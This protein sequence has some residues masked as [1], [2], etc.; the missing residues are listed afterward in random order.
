LQQDIT[1]IRPELSGG[2]APTQT[3][4]EAK[5]RKDQAL[6]QLGPQAAEMLAGAK[7][8]GRNLVVQ[9]AR[10]GSG[11]IKSSRKTSFGLQTDA[12]ELAMLAE[13]GWHCDTDGQWPMNAADTFDKLY[14]LLKEFNPEIAS[15]LGVLDPMNLERNLEVLQLPG[16]QSTFEDQ[17]RK[18]LDDVKQLLTTGPIEGMPGAPGQPSIPP[19]A[20]DDHQFVADFLRKWLVSQEGQREK[21]KNPA[22]FE[23][24]VLFQQA[25]QQMVPPAQAPE[26]AV[27]MSAS[28]SVT[29]QD[30]GPAA[31]EQVLQGAGLQIQPGAVQPQLPPAPEPPAE[32]L[33]APPAP[34]E[35]ESALPPL[36]P[37]G[38]PPQQ[39]LQ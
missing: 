25:H 12:V 39:L 21:T 11:T 14:G 10:Y 9:R 2:G 8:L 6:S 36:E 16:Y 19:D 37:Q 13:D 24:V 30:I 18:T 5:M 27:K 23:N 33:S 15:I 38:Q 26:P 17:K 20:Y 28:L 3:Y 1:G 32:D 22:G 29:P 7:D 4:R 34:E 31:T 35:Q